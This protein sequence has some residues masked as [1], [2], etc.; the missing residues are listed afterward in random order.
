MT[1]I[2]QKVQE[3]RYMMSEQ[4]KDARRKYK[5]E[6]AQKNREKMR[7][8]EARYWEKVA[9]EAAEQRPAAAEAK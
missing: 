5:R 1:D 4:A 7:E 2:T 3:D 6:W 8:Y 9:K